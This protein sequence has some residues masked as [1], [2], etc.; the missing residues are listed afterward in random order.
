MQ[1]TIT[2]LVTR[3]AELKSQLGPLQAQMKPLVTELEQTKL[4]LI[5]AMRE[6]R[7]KRTESINGYYAIRAER[8]N[9]NITDESA[10]SDWLAENDFDL[11]EYY[12]L[13]TVRVKSAAE[14][15]LKETGELV[16]GI[17]VSS[18]EYLTIKETK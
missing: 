15:A 14:S 9:I 7:S 2:P 8:K 6:G 1:D 4:E 17:E 3:I 16:P 10:V 12:K 5:E 18:T 13:D 11:S